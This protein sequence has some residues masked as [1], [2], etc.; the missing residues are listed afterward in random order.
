MTTLTQSVFPPGV[1]VGAFENSSYQAKN[2]LQPVGAPVETAL[3]DT[4]G[5]LEI[6]LDPGRYELAAPKGGLFVGGGPD[7]RMWFRPKVRSSV[8]VNLVDPKGSE[9]DL[10][11]SVAGR[12]IEVSLGTDDQEEITTTAEMVVNAINGNTDA[13]ALVT[14]EV[15][16][17]GSGEGV[18]AV[19]S[20]SFAEFAPGWSYLAVTVEAS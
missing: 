3:V 14:G 2:A 5:T 6:D 16:P 13:F 10:A 19:E 15:A 4:D 17:A 18:V 7:A 20:S 8:T 12:T 1:T 9:Q 11:V